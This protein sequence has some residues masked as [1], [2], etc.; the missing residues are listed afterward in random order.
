M[1][2]WLVDRLCVLDDGQPEDESVMPQFQWDHSEGA[3]LGAAAST[4]ILR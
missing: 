4:L 1:L 3:W 2:Q